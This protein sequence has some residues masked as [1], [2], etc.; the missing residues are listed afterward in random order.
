MEFRFLSEV[1]KNGNRLEASV[2][3]I[4]GKNAR[5]VLKKCKWPLNPLA[6]EHGVTTAYHLPRFKRIWVAKSN[7]PIFQPTQI[8]EIDPQPSGYLST[9]TKTDLDALRVR[10]GQVLLTCSGTIGNSSLVTATLDQKIFSH[11]LIRLTSQEDFSSGFIYAFLKTK[12]GNTLIRTSEYGSV[13]SHIEPDH[14]NNVPIPSPPTV[15]KRT[16]SRPCFEIVRFEG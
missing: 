15:L 13:I 6:G 9:T 4:D 11:D 12:I 10:E 5:E 1:V 2:F 7:F 8:T 3:G 14:L 16:I